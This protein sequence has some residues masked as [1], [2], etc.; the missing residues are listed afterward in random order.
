[1]V[2]HSLLH[3]LNCCT[4]DLNL[5][6]ATTSCCEVWPAILLKGDLRFWQ[7]K[8]WQSSNNRLPYRG[9]VTIRGGNSNDCRLAIS[10]LIVLLIAVGVVLYM[11]RGG[12]A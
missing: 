2:P 10:S 9:P 1:M 6:G 11:H 4:A 7:D 5:A 3:C 8:R 12:A